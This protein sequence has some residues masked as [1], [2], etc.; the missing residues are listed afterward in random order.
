MV[1]DLVARLRVAGLWAP[2]G[3]PESKLYLEAAERI[4]AMETSLAIVVKWSDEL[5]LY[6][7]PGTV[8][9]PALKQAKQVLE[10]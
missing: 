8:L 4:L 10:S 7:E 2:Q 6:A 1:S 9:V 3:E 5:G